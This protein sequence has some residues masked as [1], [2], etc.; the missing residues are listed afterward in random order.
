MNIIKIEGREAAAAEVRKKGTSK[1]VYQDF[2]KS[3]QS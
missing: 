3:S 1:D 2:E